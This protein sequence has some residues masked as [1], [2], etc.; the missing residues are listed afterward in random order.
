LAYAN[1]LTVSPGGSYPVAV[2]AGG[3][4]C[5]TPLTPIATSAGGG[6]VRIVWPG[7]V[8]LFPSTNVSTP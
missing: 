6:A 1:N 8:R 2:G 7:N 3:T 5:N 4:T